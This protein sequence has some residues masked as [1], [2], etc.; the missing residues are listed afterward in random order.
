MGLATT[1]QHD[2]SEVLRWPR[3]MQLIFCKRCKSIALA[4]KKKD[5]RHAM[6]H[7]GMSQGTAPA[8]RNEASRRLK[9]PKLT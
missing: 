1:T 2:T 8:T 6:K 7:I 4:T 9:P 5:F 3:K